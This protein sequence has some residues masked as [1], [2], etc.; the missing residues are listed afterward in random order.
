M[1]KNPTTNIIIIIHPIP[2]RKKQKTFALATVGMQAARKLD[3]PVR[4]GDGAMIAESF[5]VL[6]KNDEN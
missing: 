3:I 1:P 5:G 2:T 4:L 6:H